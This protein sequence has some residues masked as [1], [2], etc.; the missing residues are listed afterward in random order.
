MKTL[1]WSGTGLVCYRK[2]I[3]QHVEAID[4]LSKRL[5]MSTWD[6]GKRSLELLC[7]FIAREAK[8]HS[9]VF[10]NATQKRRF[11]LHII[12]SLEKIA[13]ETFKE[14][15]DDGCAVGYRTVPLDFAANAFHYYEFTYTQRQ[16]GYIVLL[17]KKTTGEIIGEYDVDPF[18][19]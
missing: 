6:I 2:Q 11:D 13:D 15:D 7:A 19:R 10:D 16:E 3:A 9:L 4:A 5:G 14:T 18:F 12:Y 17:H 8:G 1:P